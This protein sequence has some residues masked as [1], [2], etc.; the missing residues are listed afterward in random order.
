LDLADLFRKQALDPL[1]QLLTDPRHVLV[2]LD[3]TSG[4]KNSQ[5]TCE[6]TT[7]NTRSQRLIASRIVGAETFSGSAPSSSAHGPR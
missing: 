5:R 1:D 7:R 4:S 6:N 3:F 2:G